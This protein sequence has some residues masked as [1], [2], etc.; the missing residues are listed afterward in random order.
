[1]PTPTPTPTQ[2]H[3][4][5]HHS[6]L[7]APDGRWLRPGTAAYDEAWLRAHL[8]LAPAAWQARLHQRYLEKARHS[9]F[10]ANTWLRR[11]TQSMRGLLLPIS[12]TDDDICIKAD[13]LAAQCLRLAGAVTDG[14]VLARHAAAE[15]FCR[16]RGISPPRL[17]LALREAEI[18][19]AY[20]V[21]I[22]VRLGGVAALQAALEE[23]AAPALARMQDGHWWRRRLRAQHA[24]LVEQHAIALGYV[25]AAGEKYASDVACRR[26]R[27]QQRRAARALAR[28]EMVNQDGEVLTL[29]ELAEHSNANPRIR[30]SELMTRVAGFEALARELGHVA[31]F[32]TLTA[33]SRFH[34]QGGHN[35]SFAGA[36]PREA[37]A[38]LCKTWQLFRAWAARRD[39]R[40]YGFRVAEPHQDGCPHWHL[41]LFMAPDCVARFRA[42]FRRYAIR[43][44]TPDLPAPPPRL[45][46]LIHAQGM[47]R[48]ATRLAHARRA[49]AQHTHAVALRRQ[50]N[51]QVHRKCHACR[52]VRVE[53]DGT[54]SAAGY[55]AKYISKNIDGYQVQGDLYGQDAITG[56]ARVEAWAATHGIRQF[57]QIGGAPVGVWRELRRLREAAEDV[58]ATLEAARAAADD[59][60]WREYIRIQGGPTVSR[61]G[62]ALTLARTSAGEAW[63]GANQCPQPARPGRYGELPGAVVYG[64]RERLTGCALVTRR[65]SWEVHRRPAR[66]EN[67]IHAA[68]AAHATPAHSPGSPVSTGTPWRLPAGQGASPLATAHR[69]GGAQERVADGG[70]MVS[71][72]CVNN[73]TPT[74]IGDASVIPGVAGGGGEDRR[75]DADTATGGD[76][77]G[78]VR[79][80]GI[81]PN[82]YLPVNHAAI[83]APAPAPRATRPA[84]G[85]PRVGRDRLR[86]PGQTCFS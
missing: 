64:V 25:H 22:C 4:P 61:A 56:A 10:A 75:E 69:A 59:G 39:I 13:D 63:D 58:S 60:A 34:A 55:I 36:S 85:L 72:T 47:Q 74:A 43:I 81:T 28:V 3:P 73:C 79:T 86:K 15:R 44:D 48:G 27:Q 21:E 52:F 12:A 80:P 71:W 84:S 42:R 62:L 32:V 66:P 30:R 67:S 45:G 77:P 35:T 17:P 54:R 37:Q 83:A 38:W 57:Q 82:P 76:I 18:P 19:M 20:L 8:D 53:M 40:F 7:K 50:E 70:L 26:R 51:A 41:L 68:H 49:E 78:P 24:R 11:T 23:E 5:G 9:E 6:W 29:A 1:M 16:A 33:P 2:A 46:E 31:E 65:T 14:S